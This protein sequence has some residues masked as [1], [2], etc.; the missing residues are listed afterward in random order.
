MQHDRVLGD[1][2]TARLISRPFQPTNFPLFSD[3]ASQ[4]TP[5]LVGTALVLAW[6][7]TWAQT[8]GQQA[9]VIEATADAAPALAARRVSSSDTAALL[10]GVDSAQAGG[11]SSL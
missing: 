5:T 6:S 7:P 8:A 11:V 3:F 1:C 4:L 10:D 9:V 2:T